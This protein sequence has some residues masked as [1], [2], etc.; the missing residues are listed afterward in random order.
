MQGISD[1][2]KVHENAK[3]TETLIRPNAF[4]IISDDRIL[5]LCTKTSETMN[6]WLGHLN[7]LIVVETKAPAAKSKKTNVLSDE[8]IHMDALELIPKDTF[9]EVSF[10]ENKAI[11]IVLERA[12]DWAIT[13]IA[14]FKETGVQTGSALTFVNGETVIF[15]DYKQTI[16]RF[17]NW[18]PP[19]SLIFRAAPHKEGYL[20]KRKDAS[21]G[22]WRKYYFILNGG[23]LSYKATA[24]ENEKIILEIP[25]VGALVAFVSRDEVGKRFC[26]KVISGGHCLMLQASSTEEMREWA[27]IIYHAIAIANGGR[28]II[29]YERQRLL[30]EE[31]REQ[32][33]KMQIIEQETAY[34]V[35]LVQNAVMSESAEELQEALDA[36]DKV[37]L[38]GEF[39]DYS[40]EFLVKILKS[41][42]AASLPA[43]SYSQGIMGASSSTIYEEITVTGEEEAVEA[44]EAEEREIEIEEEIQVYEEVEEI[45]EV[46]IATH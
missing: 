34:I 7:A 5:H 22:V 11:G 9:Y 28:H 41:H 25:L 39:I 24:E 2:F 32:A 20:K 30:E 6:D 38:S 40:R 26:F 4:E 27:A 29:E 14:D 10:T 31:A 42:K 15:D 3:I 21:T 36:A 18:K 13:K 8:V 23:K 45:I 1:I 19:L 43:I 12:G 37:G 35:E 33:L 17:K 44:Y 16:G 46:R